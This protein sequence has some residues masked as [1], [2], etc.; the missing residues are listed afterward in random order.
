MDPLMVGSHQ[1]LYYLFTS[2]YR[3]RMRVIIVY[4]FISLRQVLV[5]SSCKLFKFDFCILFDVEI[6]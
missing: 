1:I 6:R 5:G 4:N 2:L 3:C